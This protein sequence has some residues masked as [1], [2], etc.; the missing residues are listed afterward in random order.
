MVDGYARRRRGA[1]DQAMTPWLTL[2][3][4]L[5]AATPPLPRIPIDRVGTPIPVPA[6][7][8]SAHRFGIAIA[9]DDDRLAVG[10]DGRRDGPA[11]PGLVVIYRRDPVPDRGPNRALEWRRRPQ[12]VMDRL[13][14]APNPVSNDG[15]GSA[16]ALNEGRL[17]IGAP[18]SDDER[19]AVWL[20]DLD[21][22]GSPHRLSLA[23]DL[24]PGDRLGESIAIRG[25]LAVVG[26]PRADVDDRI[27]RGRAWAVVLPRTKDAV[28]QPE[29][30]ELQPGTSI[31][32]MRFGI[33][34]AIG[35]SIAVGVPGADVVIDPFEPD[36]VVDRAGEVLLFDLGP[37]FERCG[38]R[39]RGSP[40]PLDRT[41]TAI[42]WDA[43]RLVVGSPRA[44]CGIGRGGM[45]TMFGRVRRDVGL[46][47]R[48][49]GGFGSVLAVAS[50][51]LAVGVP[52]RRDEDGRLDASSILCAIDAG[53][54]APTLELD[55]LGAG[56]IIDLAGDERGD[57]LV[58]AAARHHEE[59]SLPGA[60]WVVEFAAIPKPTVEP[61]GPGSSE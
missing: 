53:G 44:D 48:V 10:V 5:V 49:D 22:G 38:R 60:V 12:W 26:A 28:I 13:I 1:A 43:H 24:S 47:C 21:A 7:V 23:R 17:L 27:D 42:T 52:G 19:G 8:A 58:I 41:G 40:G 16:L 51:R 14:Q 25:D 35:A 3:A 50:G 57:R 11:D 56:V 18:G 54:I 36:A 55:G 61:A 2:L 34:L 37:D 32:G 31:T 6:A 45:L 29:I 9:I 20:V 39:R 30:H 15:F 4:I 46:P 59:E 33:D